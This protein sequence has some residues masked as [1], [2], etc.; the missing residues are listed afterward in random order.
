M[1]TTLRPIIIPT[2]YKKNVSQIG[3]AFLKLMK[4]YTF[5]HTIYTYKYLCIFLF[6]S[7]LIFIQSCPSSSE[8]TEQYNHLFDN[9]CYLLYKKRGKSSKIVPEKEIMREIQETTN[10]GQLKDKVN[11][12]I[13]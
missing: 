11:L 7:K 3:S 2:K 6:N 8:E 10:S 9:H 1:K 4:N 5:F 13:G 12:I